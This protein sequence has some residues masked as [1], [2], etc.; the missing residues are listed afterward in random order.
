MLFQILS[1]NTVQ[2]RSAHLARSLALHTTMH[3]L[4]LL[5][6]SHWQLNTIDAENPDIADNSLLPDTAKLAEQLRVCLQEGLLLYESAVIFTHPNTVEIPSSCTVA[7][8][9]TAHA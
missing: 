5:V 3:S 2:V 6:W 9:R 1:T 4:S 7:A 8:S